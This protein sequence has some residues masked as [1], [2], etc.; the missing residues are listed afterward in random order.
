MYTFLSFTG[1]ASREELKEN[2]LRW[3]KWSLL[4]GTCSGSL[5]LR[6]PA[7]KDLMLPVSRI[8]TLGGGRGKCLF[9]PIIL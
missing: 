8:Q 7:G 2:V 9:T 4:P 1:S 6:I 5:S 3:I